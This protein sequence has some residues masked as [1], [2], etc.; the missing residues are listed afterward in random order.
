MLVAAPAGYGKTTAV[1]AWCASR[2]PPVAW[3]RLDAGDNDP[4]RFWTYI[5]TAVDRIRPGLGRR[6][7]H[8]LNV[9]GAS[10]E[11]AVD[12]LANALTGFGE[13]LVIVLDDLQSVTST[14]CMAAL[15]HAI[16]DFPASVRLVMIS[17]TDPA[18]R[19]AQLRAS[20]RLT[21]LR[22]SELAFTAAEAS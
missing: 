6:S 8:R 12:E 14:D 9:L 16:E 17:R 1:R 7:L 5:A 15:D 19:L 11:G 18:L 13:E 4:V 20:G 3:V 22:A 10:I 21:E 2:T